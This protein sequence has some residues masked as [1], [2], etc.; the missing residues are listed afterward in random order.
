MTARS[1]TSPTHRNGGS[2]STG[3]LF[4]FS[5]AVLLAVIGIVLSALAYQFGKPDGPLFYWGI[6]P[7]TPFVILAAISLFPRL[8]P[9]P[10]ILGGAAGGLLAVALSYGLLYY[11]SV[12]YTGGGANIGLGILVVASPVLLPLGMVIGG[13]LGWVIGK[14]RS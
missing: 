10:A 1:D 13:L 9:I 14:R 6:L 4:R 12:N 3:S 5:T 2:V 7:G 11:N 8:I